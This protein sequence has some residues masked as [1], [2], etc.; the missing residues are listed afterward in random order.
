MFEDFKMGPVE[1]LDDR[2]IAENHALLE[3]EG[4]VRRAVSY[5]AH[6]LKLLRG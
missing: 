6:N 4:E 2:L 3:P 5:L 1:I